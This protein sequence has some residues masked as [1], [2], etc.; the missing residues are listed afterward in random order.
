MKQFIQHE[1]C[2]R[3]RECC[4][5]RADRQ[6]F[7]P[8]FTAAEIEAIRAVRGDDMPVFH[9]YKGSENVFQVALVPASQ[10]DDVYPYVCPFLDED[11]YACG[12]YDVRPFDCRTWPFIVQKVV[13]TGR[14]LVA[15]FTGD[16]CLALDEFEPG[17]MEAYK[18][19]FAALV[20]S[21]KYVQLLRHSPELI[22]EHD[23]DG[24]YHTV[25]LVDLTDT[26]TAPQSP[27]SLAVSP[28][29]DV[30]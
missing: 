2:Q 19:Y 21:D 4:R 1:Q 28:G 23:E 7:A 10:P 16:V 13:Q 20:T 22:W 14:T 3:C 8:L 25:P 9:P 26:L 18:A 17:D 29:D 15:H 12:I 24:A 11:N 27:D 5:F 6:Y 30:R